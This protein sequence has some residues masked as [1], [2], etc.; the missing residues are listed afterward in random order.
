MKSFLGVCAIAI[1]LFLPFSLVAQNQQPD[2][3]DRNQGYG[4][5]QNSWQG[6]LS[7]D[8]QGRFDSYFS[9]WLEYQQSNDRGN[10]N[11]MEDRMRDVMSRNNIPP[12]VSFEQIA[13]NGNPGYRVDARQGGN[14]DDRGA[15]RHDHRGQWQN[16]LSAKDQR[17]FDSYYTRWLDAGRNRDRRQGV[18][19]ERRMRDLMSRYS[20]P[21]EMRFSEIASHAPERY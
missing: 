3:R 17:R 5:S 19:M 10:Q 15:W 11:S 7:A 18:N 21:P 14:R 4:D 6:R 9:R 2:D 16:R 13:S 20:I 12:D 1:G 8:D